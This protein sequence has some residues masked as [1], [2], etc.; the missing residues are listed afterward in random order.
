MS[1][2]TQFDAIRLIYELSEIVYY[3][4]ADT[5][6]RKD[7]LRKLRDYIRNTYDESVWKP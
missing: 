6:P 1:Q 2:P 7:A 5:S 3:D 4:V